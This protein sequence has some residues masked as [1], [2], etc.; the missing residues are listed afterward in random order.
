MI[1]RLS[2][3]WMR[4]ALVGLLAL[5][6]AV[7]VHAAID[8]FVVFD[9]AGHLSSGVITWTTGDF[10]YYN[11]NPPLWRLVAS[12]PVALFSPQ[13]PPDPQASKEYTRPEI[14]SAN[15]FAAANADR[16]IFFVRLFRI[17]PVVLTIVT[18]WLV[19]HLAARAHGCVAGLAAAGLWATCP[20]ALGF[21]HVFTNDIPLTFAILVVQSIIEQYRQRPT[22][23][24]LVLAGAAIGL[25]VLSKYSAILLIPFWATAL[26]AYG[27]RGS[28]K[29]VITRMATA[30]GVAFLVIHLGFA[31]SEPVT[32][33]GEPRFVSR[34]LGGDVSGTHSGNRF[35]QTVLA[36][37]PVPLPREM[38][39]GLDRQQRDFDTKIRSYMCGE[40]RQGGWW[41]YYLYALGVKLPEGLLLLILLT[42]A[43]IAM[44]ICPRRRLELD[45][46]PALLLLIGTSAQTGFSHHLRYC[47]PVVALACVFCGRA[48]AAVPRWRSMG[49]IITAILVVSSAVSTLVEHPHHMAYFNAC[50]GG[51]HR[52]HTH[53]LDSNLDWGQDLL[54][55]RRWLVHS[56]NG[57]P[58]YLAYYHIVDPAVVGIKYRSPAGPSMP[59]SP[60]YHVISANLLYGY[61]GP[62]FDGR[63]RLLGSSEGTFKLYRDMQ[64]VCIIGSSLHVFMVD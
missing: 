28:V 29:R 50:S 37:L 19:W 43:G 5:Q 49:R 32:T 46:I 41:Y 6:G 3:S 4:F 45:L 48:T 58:I 7:L 34:L 52:G 64:P 42:S 55:L 47:L 60:G 62:Y 16:Y 21:G 61:Q 27:P 59:L 11:V 31:F 22:P 9:E 40:L 25:A 26:A 10:R 2:R 8:D 14:P 23:A 44:R 20:L 12:A 39:I 17:V 57:E 53:L 33:L 56:T 63:G 15:S 36:D 35:E 18:T 38:F 30:G 54:R 13:V 51:R 24:V 1:D